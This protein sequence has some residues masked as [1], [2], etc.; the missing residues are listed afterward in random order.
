[1]FIAQ[2][3]YAE[4]LAKILNAIL[5]ANNYELSAARVNIQLRSLR[6]AGE[7]LEYAPGYEPLLAVV[8]REI[9]EKTAWKGRLEKQHADNTALLERC[10]VRPSE[11]EKKFHRIAADCTR[12]GHS[13]V[14][15]PE[16]R[17]AA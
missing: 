9:A 1:M 2:L 8:R 13:C 4:G 11:Y 10:G 14:K 15:L 7:A 16:W 5:S 17:Q 3:M 6:R 12:I